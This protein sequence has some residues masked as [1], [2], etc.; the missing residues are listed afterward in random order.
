MPMLMSVLFLGILATAMM[1]APAQKSGPCDR[2]CLEGFADQYLAAMVA[3]DASRAPFAK[4]LIFT[5]NAVVLPPTEGL[6]FT[7]SGLGNGWAA[8]LFKQ[9]RFE[10]SGL[11]G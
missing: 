3:R 10:S 5:E 4:N 8:P 11:G 2:A 6:W 9:R 1:A 7:P